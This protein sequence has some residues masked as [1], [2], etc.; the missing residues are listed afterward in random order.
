M[1]ARGARGR[2]DGCGRQVGWRAWYW[3][4]MGRVL[5]PIVL[6]LLLLAGGW[7]RWRGENAR[8]VARASGG[9]GTTVAGGQEKLSPIGWEPGETAARGERE[10]LRRRILEAM[11]ARE[12]TAVGEVGD[13]AGAVAAAGAAGKARAPEDEAVGGGGLVDRTGNHGYLLKVM[14]EELMPLADE[15]YALARG[16]RPELA[17]MLVLDVEI[18]GDEE[19]GGV[20]EAIGPG[21]GNE[22][23]EPLLLECMRE[24]ILSMTLPAPPQGGRDALSLSMPLAPEAAE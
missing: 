7:Y 8:V 6:V 15:C 20:V 22:L 23:V 12:R 4:G 2:S 13:G 9:R 10:A 5:G 1:W 17:G 21:L 24:S 18:L 11:E 16:T 19:I 3:D 14:N